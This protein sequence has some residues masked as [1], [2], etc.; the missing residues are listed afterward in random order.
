VR[1]EVLEVL[2]GVPD[3]VCT[4]IQQSKHEPPARQNITFD[5]AGDKPQLPQ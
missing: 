3:T 2:M 4:R 5:R 1:R